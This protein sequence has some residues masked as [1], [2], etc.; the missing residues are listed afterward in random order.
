MLSILSFN[1]I[2]TTTVCAFVMYQQPSAAATA[3][4]VSALFRKL[5]SNI[6]LPEVTGLLSETTA[7]SA[8]QLP[9]N[10]TLENITLRQHVADL[11]QRLATDRLILTFTVLQ[12]DQ[13]MVQHYTGLKLDVLHIL[14]G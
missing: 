13:F 8:E 1:Y 14:Y 3:I 10:I 4:S 12:H 11:Q 6:T 7:P 9:D 2:S 5:H